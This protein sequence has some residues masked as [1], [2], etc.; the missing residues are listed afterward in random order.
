MQPENLTDIGLAKLAAGVAG[1]FVSLRFIQGSPIQRATSFVGGAA[2]SYFM[3]TPSTVW[4]GLKGVDGAEGVVG[5][6]IGVFGMTIVSKMYDVIQ[7]ADAQ[8]MA[9]ALLD[10]V[11]RKWGA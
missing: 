2:L 8:V 5:L 7:G 1:S 3:S 4:L 11:K 9:T 10:W 6:F